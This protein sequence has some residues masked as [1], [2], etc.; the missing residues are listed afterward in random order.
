MAEKPGFSEEPGF[1]VS[2]VLT[3]LGHKRAGPFGLLKREH[4]VGM[5]FINV[6]LI[7]HRIVDVVQNLLEI[8]VGIEV[9]ITGSRR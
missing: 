6:E 9:W 3:L 1:F 5:A 4:G 7:A 2:R 8:E